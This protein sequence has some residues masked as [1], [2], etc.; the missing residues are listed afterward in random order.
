MPAQDCSLCHDVGGAPVYR[1]SLLRAVIVDDADLPGFVRVI[2][3]EHVKEMTD[4]DVAAR[5]ELLRVVFAAEEAIRETFKPLKVNLASLGNVVPHV[6]WHVI[7]RFAD[8]AFYPQSIWGVRQRDTPSE[9]L[10]Q[11]RAMLPMLRERLLG[12]LGGA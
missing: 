10:A 8:D 4:L 5:L 7:A 11:R 6:H 12:K 1:N 9:F 3:N 2:V